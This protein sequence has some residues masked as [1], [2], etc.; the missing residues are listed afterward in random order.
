M[1]E[2]EHHI[3]DFSTGLR[4]FK[5]G[6]LGT[7]N[8]TR[9][10]GF[11]VKNKSIEVLDQVKNPIS[12]DITWPFPKYFFLSACTLY[13]TQNQV[14]EVGPNWVPRLVLSLPPCK[15]YSFADFGPY[16]V[17]ATST[18][19]VFQRNPDGSWEL[20]TSLPS[21][22]YVTNFKGQIVGASGR[23]VIWSAIGRA[24][25][26]IDETGEAG[27]YV[28]PWN[29]DV[30]AVQP[31]G[32]A[33]LVF[34]QLG[35]LEIKPVTEPLPTF[36]ITEVADFGLANP[37][38]VC[39]NGTMLLFVDL[40]GSLWGMD[41]RTDTANVIRTKVRPVELGYR[42]FFDSFD[43]ENISI[44][45]D[46]VLGK[47]F[48]SDGEECFVFSNG[49]LT[50]ARQ[51][52]TSSLNGFGICT[53]PDGPSMI[54]TDSID[55]NVRGLKT[56]NWLEF[57][58]ETDQDPRVALFWRTSFREPFKATAWTKLNHRGQ[59]FLR[60]S[61]LEFRIGLQVDDPKHFRLDRI[62]ARLQLSDKRTQR[63]T[64]NVGQITS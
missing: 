43:K 21:M 30:L 55:F 22:T 59:V 57:G 17:G 11:E 1:R 23:R 9:C 31:L 12:V 52:V 56:I 60:T 28:S 7:L 25:F 46:G 45:Y 10:L 47:F 32:D 38:A 26:G 51:L 34:G 44:T 8:L 18:G 24:E 3:T 13:V 19:T 50:E 27:N 64:V 35:V 41:S 15:G 39:S 29:C 53:A 49:A 61:A 37:N 42:E 36:A 58:L 48:I 33:L 40:R 16:V 20:S 54:V 6:P 4:R 62:T 2:F 63:G 14:F 5:N